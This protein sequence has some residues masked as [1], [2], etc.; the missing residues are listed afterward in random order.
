[1]A[2]STNK[3]HSFVIMI[4]QIGMTRFV[5]FRTT[6]AAAGRVRCCRQRH[7]HG[8]PHP[9]PHCP[10]ALSG[11]AAHLMPLCRHFRSCWNNAL[12]PQRSCCCCC[13][14]RVRTTN[15]DGT[16]VCGKKGSSAHQKMTL[17]HETLIPEL[18]RHQARDASVADIRPKKP[19]CQSC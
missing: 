18:T 8:A 7:H 11:A 9:L 13:C 4:I 16:V 2:E 19:E 15:G 12:L 10:P 14:C 6:A 17:S 5:W 1:M 3:H